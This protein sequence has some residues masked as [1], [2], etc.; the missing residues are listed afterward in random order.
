[1]FLC[2][3]VKGFMVFAA[4][5]LGTRCGTLRAISVESPSDLR[6]FDRWF[7]VRFS[8]LGGAKRRPSGRV[9]L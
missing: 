4:L 2:G 9:V 8:S 7:A 6:R 3:L 1:M 5:R